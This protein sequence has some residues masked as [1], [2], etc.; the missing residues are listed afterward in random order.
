L[1]L[2]LSGQIHQNLELVGRHLGEFAKVSVQT[3]ISLLVT[4]EY[5]KLRAALL[6]ALWPFPEARQAVAS[7]L[8]SIEGAAAQEPVPNGHDKAPVVIDAEPLEAGNG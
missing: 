4:P 8:H 7:V 6:Q 1:R 2:R 3:N 5:L